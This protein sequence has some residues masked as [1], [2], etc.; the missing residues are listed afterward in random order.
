MV[1]DNQF[2][3]KG[4]KTMNI[5]TSE[6]LQ[7]ILKI[8]ERQ[9]KALMRTKGFPSC[10]IGREYRVTESALQQWLDNTKSIKL[11]YTKC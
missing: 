10:K 7:N 11:D 1:K 8:G 3:Q 5:L 6:D 9:A 2:I 4:H